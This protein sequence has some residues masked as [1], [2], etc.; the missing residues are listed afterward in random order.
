M[1]TPQYSNQKAV[2]SCPYYS[3]VRLRTTKAGAGPFTFTGD[4][5]E[6]K[7]FAYKIGDVM[8]VAGF[9][10]G[11]IAT[12]AET[13]MIKASETRDNADVLIW[14]ISIELAKGE[15][16]LARD[17]WRVC[18]VELSLSGTDS[19]QLGR[20]AFFPQCGGLFGTQRSFLEAG[21]LVETSGPMWGVVTNGNPN[22]GSFFKLPE[23]L[24]WEALGSGKK[25]TSLVV[26]ITPTAA[27]VENAADRAAVAGAAP[28]ASGRVEAFTTPA[29]QADGTFVDLCIRLHTVQVGERSRNA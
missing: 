20:L 23:P 27:V 10:A 22:A 5:T 3:T 18:V 12:K 16:K 28:G 7:A 4:T 13:N 17:W 25:D 8:D 29:D 11:T 24:L 19:Y 2:L 6:K 26:K 21:Q 14:G 9:P 1:P 15:I